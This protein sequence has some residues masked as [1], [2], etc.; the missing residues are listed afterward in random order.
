MED[1]II[2]GSHKDYFIP[3]VNFNAETGVCEISG[4]SF[5][6]DTVDFYKPILSWLKEYTETVK[7]P[8]AFII[9]LSYFNTSTSRS[10]LDILNILKT[11]EENDGELIINWHYDPQD[12]DMEEDIEDYMIDTGL[13]INLIPVE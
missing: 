9:K 2:E 4:E 1:L 13:D 12:V 6:E 8:L 7:K 10:L 5:L 11:Y 3:S